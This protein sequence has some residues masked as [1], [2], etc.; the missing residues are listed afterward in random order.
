MTHDEPNP[1][2][3]SKRY[4]VAAIP[5]L[6]L[7]AFLG[8]LWFVTGVLPSEE[9]YPDGSQKAIGYVKRD[10]LTAYR[11]HGHWATYHQNGQ[12]A[13]D[14]FYEN[15]EKTGIWKYWDE[16]GNELPSAPD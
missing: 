2:R 1:S 12:M 7:V 9:L 4:I 14:G 13:S 10:G 15:G 8:Y 6:V 16:H 3:S 11:R 5:V